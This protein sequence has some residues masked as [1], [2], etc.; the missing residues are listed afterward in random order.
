MMRF[1][2]FDSKSGLLHIEPLPGT[3]E[4]ATQE[5]EMNKYASM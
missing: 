1:V 2:F 3:G 4:S 5:Q